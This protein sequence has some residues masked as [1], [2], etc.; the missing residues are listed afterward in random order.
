MSS[1]DPLEE[2]TLHDL[3]N[4]LALIISLSELASLELLEGDLRSDLVAI[5][6][7]AVGAFALV[8]KLRLA[9]R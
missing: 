8:P 2:E 9:T 6:D 4:K 3:K 7:A 1:P 5:H